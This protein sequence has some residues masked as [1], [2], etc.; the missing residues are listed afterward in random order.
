MAEEPRGVGRHVG[1]TRVARYTRML[2]QLDTVFRITVD[3]DLENEMIVVSCKKVTFS[4]FSYGFYSLKL[5]FLENLRKDH[6]SKYFLFNI[7][8]QKG[9]VDFCSNLF[10]NYCTV[11]RSGYD[12]LYVGG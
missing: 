5:N 9:F 8:S 12:I 6:L 3:Q 10:L 1:T 2:A 4:N 7:Y 11:Y